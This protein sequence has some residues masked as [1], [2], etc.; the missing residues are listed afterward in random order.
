MPLKLPF[1]RKKKE[2]CTKVSRKEFGT[3]EIR[4][5]FFLFFLIVSSLGNYTHRDLKIFDVLFHILY[6]RITPYTFSLFNL[7]VA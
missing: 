1:Y 3:N 6:I 2:K 4:L 5:H 7:I